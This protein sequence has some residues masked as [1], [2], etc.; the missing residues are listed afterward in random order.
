MLCSYLSSAYT[1]VTEIEQ[2]E[3]DSRTGRERSRVERKAN[4]GRARVIESQR[5][6]QGRE[7]KVET[8]INLGQGSRQVSA[9]DLC[10]PFS[11][12]SFDSI[13]PRIAIVCMLTVQT[14]CR[15]LMPKYSGRSAG[16]V[17]RSRLPTMS[18][19]ALLRRCRRRLA[20]SSA[21]AAARSRVALGS[22]CCANA[23]AP[24]R[25]HSA[26]SLSRRLSS[27]LFC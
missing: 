12:A 3:F 18:M 19:V 27:C 25:V 5:D 13:S 16:R 23:A 11:F 6:A 9:S 8:L 10:P 15:A 21:M 20:V 22:E 2:R 1:Q 26:A 4:D 14:R 24:V 17:R 7:E